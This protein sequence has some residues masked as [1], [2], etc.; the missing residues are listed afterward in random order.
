MQ[1]ATS[2][3]GSIGPVTNSSRASTHA[4]DLS[5]LASI[6]PVVVTP[7]SLVDGNGTSLYPSLSGSFTVS[8][9]GSAV[10]SWPLG[11]SAMSNS[12]VT[13]TFSG[14]GLTYT[15]PVS[16]ATATITSGM[17]SFTLLSDFSGDASTGNWTLTSETSES[18][19]STAAL[20]WTIARAGG[21]TH[22]MTLYGY[23]HVM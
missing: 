4:L 18:V 17:Y 23:R 13:V 5:R 16:G 19:S 21:A 10:T 8:S 2:S 11:T 22:A 15:D 12:V 9:T 6:G 20:S 3:N 1:S 7:S 14:G